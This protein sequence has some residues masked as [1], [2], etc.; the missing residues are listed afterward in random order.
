MTSVSRA[1]LPIIPIYI[2][3]NET[4]MNLLPSDDSSVYDLGI[5]F[6]FFFVLLFFVFEISGGHLSILSALNGWVVSFILIRFGCRLSSSWFVCLFRLLHPPPFQGL[7]IFVETCS[8][9]SHILSVWGRQGLTIMRGLFVMYQYPSDA[10][11]LRALD[12]LCNWR[13]GAN[14]SVI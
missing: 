1:Q 12:F 9:S 6:Y 14:P 8:V 13:L 5:L 7:W 11:L 10:F 3:R 4:H 2:H